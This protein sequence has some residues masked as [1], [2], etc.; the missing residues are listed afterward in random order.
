MRSTRIKHV[1]VYRQPGEFAAWPA[2]FGLWSWGA[3]VLAVFATGKL[4]PKGDIHE[5][6]RGHPFIPCQARSMDGGLTWTTEAF[7][8]P[9]P[10]GPQLS[11]DEHV[12]RELRVRHRID[13]GHDLVALEQ[14]L[15]FTDPETAILCARTGLA[16][17]TVSWFYHSRSRGCVWQGP[18]R[19]GGIDLPLSA[20]TD[21]V[22]LGA[23]D[24]LFML[25][26]DK[27]DGS[28]G[29][30]LC[31]RTRDGGQSFE[32][33]GFVGDEPAGYS[34]MPASARLPD[35][36]VL[37]L[38]RRMGTTSDKGWIEAFLSRDL[39]RTWIP[40]GR[41]V[42]NT[43]TGG[44]PPA[45]CLTPAGTLAVVYGCRE[46][47]FGIRMRTSTDGGNGWSEEKVIRDDGGTP[48][49]GYPRIVARHDGSLL[50]IYYFNQGKGEER[51]IAASLIVD[52][53]LVGPSNRIRSHRATNHPA[54]GTF[55]GS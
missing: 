39:G 22:P 19:F 42:E 21:I 10:G 45:L 49:L 20:R 31:A 40:L 11:S 28:E 34:I 38:V 15:D 35:G 8:A 41:V 4:G 29:R 25:T 24:A 50:T 5:L 23:H 36:N 33:Q 47:P 27:Q 51:Y 54:L 44:N 46:P 16:G 37:T 26:T 43:G 18:Y 52:R 2:N 9:V 1:D 55:S 32:V 13:P 12:E 17:N 3:E 6:D 14:P 30:V 53:L 48:D 7:L